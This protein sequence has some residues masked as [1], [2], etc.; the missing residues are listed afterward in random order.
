MRDP[1]GGRFLEDEGLEQEL[2]ARMVGA[3]GRAGLWDEL[4]TD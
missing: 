1:D 2:L 4:K 3:I